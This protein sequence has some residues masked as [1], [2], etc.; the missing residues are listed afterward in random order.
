MEHHEDNAQFDNY[1]QNRLAESLQLSGGAGE[2]HL[3]LADTAQE[4]HS[5]PG[6]ASSKSDQRAGDVDDDEEWKY[7]H[8]VQQ[9]EKLQQ[10]Q[11]SLE[12]GNGFS[13]GRPSEDLILGNGAA[14]GFTLAYEEEDV[15]VI[16]NDGDFSTNS[17]TTTSTGEVPAQDQQHPKKA[18]QLAEQH[19][20][21]QMQSQDQEDEDELSSVA[22]T[23]GTSS[24]SENNPT[25]LEQEEIV[26]EPQPVVQELLQCSDNKENCDFVQEVEENHSQLNP[27][28]VAFIPST[29]SHPSSPLSAVEE[30]LLGLP[31]RQLLA[32]GPLDDLVAESPRK[33]SARENMDAIAVP[34]ER[35]FDIEADKRPHELEQESDIFNAGHLE[36]QLLNGVGSA[37]PAASTD[38]LDHGPETSVDLDLSLDQLPAGGDIVKQPLYVDNNASI[39]DILNSVQPLP[40]QVGDEKELLH[41][42]EKELVSQSP[43]IEEL[44]FQQEFQPELDRQ[45]LFNNS[46]QNLMQA[47]FYFEHTS[48]EAQNDDKLEQE[49]LPGESSEMFTNHSL[50]MSDTVQQTVLSR[51][52]NFFGSS[53]LTEE[54]YEPI[55][56][57][58]DD[59]T[60]AP[61]LDITLAKTSLE[62]ELICP[63]PP[64]PAYISFDLDAQDASKSAEQKELPIYGN[65]VSEEKQILPPEEQLL[66][67]V[68]DSVPQKEELPAIKP[69]FVE[70]HIP[71]EEQIAAS[72]EQELPVGSE[73]PK[74]PDAV[75]KPNNSQIENALLSMRESLMEAVLKT[76]KEE[77][78]AASS[79]KLANVAAAATAVAAAI[80]PAAKAKPAAA[81]NAIKKTTT[82][83]IKTS[84]AEATKPVAA[85]PRTAPVAS[86]TTSTSFKSTKTSTTAPLTATTRKPLSSNAASNLISTRPATAPVSKAALGTKTTASKSTANKSAPTTGPES[87]ARTTA[88]PLSNTL[89]RKPATIGS[90]PATGVNAAARRPVTSSSGAGSASS[91]PRLAV[92]TTAPRS[93]PNTTTSVRKVPS[94]NATSPSARSPAKP[95][96]I[97]LGRSTS[98][99]TTTTTTTTTTAK[100]FTARPAPKFTHSANSTT[101]NGSTIR[102]LLVPSSSTVTS[103][104]ILR[105]SSPLKASPAKTTVKTLTPKPKEGATTKA[106]PAELKTRR[107][108]PLK[109]AT[110]IRAAKVASA[111]ITLNTNGGINAE[112]ATKRNGNGLHVVEETQQ[113]IQNQPD[114]GHVVYPENAEVSSLNF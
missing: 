51:N 103:A 98:S 17:N 63:E 49:Q 38:V 85:R 19:Q 65:L 37:E 88:R 53:E 60:F 26:L 1:L 93:I 62:D 71:T 40:T 2:Q 13:G 112:E 28:A 41:V 25:P 70:K 94:T 67:A 4:E 90:G 114:Q 42:E 111:E 61:L 3:N 96:T 87:G 66:P 18:D 99:T 27:N 113:P 23:Y 15:E 20:Q 102:R 34:D 39:E 84:V 91:K 48:I 44:Q 79:A 47:S 57:P 58:N 104:A 55:P 72:E 77:D 30:P 86:K 76:K 24:L 100:T 31:A 73:V 45:G 97:N 101:S 105:K 56:R 74:L 83:S 106:S 29:G 8:E 75:E 78:I 9:T 12:T 52:S 35:E 81:P 11:L 80:K 16:K 43:S 33:G 6:I 64:I 109:G 54:P 22:T 14:A 5:A 32:V 7:I 50:L 21:Q 92:T 110:P 59:E 46:D 10:Q 82:S 107:T 95:A 108:T 36:M 89:A 68:G 69:I